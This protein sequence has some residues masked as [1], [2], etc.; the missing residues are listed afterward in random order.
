MTHK[1][2]LCLLAL[3]GLAACSSPPPPRPP[4]AL[5]QM[6]ASDKA[7]WR[8]A[9]DG[10]WAAARS[11]F[12][13]ARRLHQA[14]DDVAGVATATINLSTAQ[15]HLGN[16]EEALR[17]LNIV[18][19][20]AAMPYP[21]PL[22]A[23]A[24]FRKAV[25]MA[26]R[27]QEREAN[28]A[29]DASQQLCGSCQLAAG[30]SNLRARLALAKGDYAAALKLAKSAADAAGG[31]KEE[32]A[33]AR[34]HSAFAEAALGQNE[35]ALAHYQAALELDKQMGI[36]ARIAE[37]L[38]GAAKAL[39]RLGRRNEAASYAHRAAAV[40]DMVRGRLGKPAP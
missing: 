19:A 18:L 29:L 9:R 32:L 11:L 38:E 2:L 35:E 24:A 10:D 12:E 33:N 20:D 1:G 39:E 3:A 15:H 37:D 26:D 8:A 40:R 14:Q 30:I 13:Q 36:S 16:D 7:A 28:A 34:R 5:E 17:L 6:A 22:R 4:A 21:A 25:I 23:N 31:E 27:G